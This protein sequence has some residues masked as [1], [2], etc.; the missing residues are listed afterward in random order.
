M[1]KSIVARR[2]ALE[3]EVEEAEEEKNVT[4]MDVQVAKVADRT[5][6]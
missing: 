2:K 6:L 3:E 5:M 1:A 4:R